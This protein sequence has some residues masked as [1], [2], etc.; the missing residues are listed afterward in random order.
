VAYGE[1]VEE[2]PRTLEKLEEDKRILTN[3]SEGVGPE[4]LPPSWVPLWVGL[5]ESHTGIA[6]HFILKAQSDLE[7]W[8]IRPAYST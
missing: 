1:S 7:K 2:R 5:M 6:R 3:E 8:Y 4:F